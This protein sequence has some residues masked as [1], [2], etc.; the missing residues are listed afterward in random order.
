MV[1]RE[2]LRQEEVNLLMK[3]RCL[4]E[5]FGP[6]RM[7]AGSFFLKI[8]GDGADA[9]VPIFSLKT[10]VHPVGNT[11]TVLLIPL[12][13]KIYDRLRFSL[14]LVKARDPRSR[15]R[16]VYFNPLIHHVVNGI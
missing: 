3:Q 7:S 16:G 6:R 10:L 5:F 4:L 1:R 14:A 13:G 15:G 2:I 12:E 11:V 8:A 9:L